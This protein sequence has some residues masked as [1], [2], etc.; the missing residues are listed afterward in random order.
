MKKQYRV[1]DTTIY[2]VRPVVT[3]YQVRSV[4]RSTRRT[5]LISKFLN[6]VVSVLCGFPIVSLIAWISGFQP[7][8]ASEVHDFVIGCL[9]WFAAG[10]IVEMISD[11]LA[12]RGR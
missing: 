9:I 8:A 6:F 11:R 12:R 2:T 10:I 7:V 4:E 1:T 3:E 5:P